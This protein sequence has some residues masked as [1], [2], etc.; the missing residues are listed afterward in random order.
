MKPEHYVNDLSETVDRVRELFVKCRESCPPPDADPVAIAKWEGAF[1][2]LRAVL[3]E[4]LQ[5]L[6]DAWEKGGPLW[7]STEVL[8][9]GGDPSNIVRRVVSEE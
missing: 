2:A 7:R 5:P 4:E 8:L 9:A 6:L 3:S 1:M